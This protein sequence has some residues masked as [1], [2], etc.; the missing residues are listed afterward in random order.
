MKLPVSCPSCDNILSVTLLKCNKCNTQVNGQYELP[1][2][3]K[4][5]NEEQS[6]VLDFFLTSG[7]IKEIASQQGVSYPTMRNRMDDL[8]AKLKQLQKEAKKK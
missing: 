7:S 4:L 3:L 2:F 6:F 1:V 8:I 5:T